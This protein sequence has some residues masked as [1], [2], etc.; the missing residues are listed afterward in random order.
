[1]NARPRRLIRRLSLFLAGGV[2]LC[3]PLPWILNLAP[4]HQSLLARLNG[5]L[6]GQLTVDGLSFSPYTSRLELRGLVLL[7]RTGHP[8]L[9]V[10][11]LELVVSLWSLTRRELNVRLLDLEDPWVRLETGPDGRLTLL[12]V[13][14]PLLVPK[15]DPEIP[16]AK[17]PFR[18]VVD[19]L[20]ITGL[21]LSLS[22]YAGLDTAE[23]A[24][25][26]L[27]ASGAWPDRRA[28]VDLGL[29]GLDLDVDSHPLRLDSLAFAGRYEPD[30]L[31]H[32][33]LAASG[34]G[35]RLVLKGHAAAPW[36]DTRVDVTAGWRIDL[37]H[38]GLQTWL[39]RSGGGVLHGKLASQGSLR[40]PDLQA[41]LVLTG[42]EHAP[43]VLDSL[44]ADLDL[45]GRVLT[46]NERLHLADGGTQDMEARVDAR[47]ALPGGVWDSLR[48]GALAWSVESAWQNLE[49]APWQPASLASGKLHGELAADG[50]GI[51]WPGLTAETRL[52]LRVTELR[53]VGRNE[54]TGGTATLEGRVS[55]VGWRVDDLLVRLPG[56]QV[57]ARGT[58]TH[59]RNDVSLRLDYQVES[60]RLPL[61]APVLD[62]DQGVFSGTLAAVG[63]WRDPRV[64]LAARHGGG[65]LAGVA[66]DSLRLALGL[67]AGTLTLS[68]DTQLTGGGHQ[69]LELLA[70]SRVARTQGLS[71]WGHPEAADWNTTL[72]VDSLA[73]A[74]LFPALADSG[75][76]TGSLQAT[77]HG[78][79]PRRLAADATLRLEGNGL[80]VP[81][82]RDP[83]LLS[84]T[85]HMTA[86]AGVYTLDTLGLGL[87]G[88]ELTGN[89]RVDLIRETLQGLA[90]VDVPDLST[91]PLD[92]GE[93]LAG[94]LSA[95]LAIGGALRAPRAELRLDADDL[96]TPWQDV[97][98]LDLRV[99][100]SGDSTRVDTCS[101]ILGDG[102]GL[103]ASGGLYP[104]E[105]FDVTLSSDPLPLTLFKLVRGSAQVGG[106]VE[107]GLTGGGTRAHPLVDGWLVGRGF[108]FRGTDLPDL[109]LKVTGDGDSLNLIATQFFNLNGSYHPASGAVAARLEIPEQDLDAYLAMAGMGAFSLRT[110]VFLAMDGYAQSLGQLQ[111]RL[112]VPSLALTA[113]DRPIA[114]ARDMAAVWHHGQLD[115]ESIRLETPLDGFLEITGS[116]SPG[117]LALALEADLP[118]EL[119]VPFSPDLGDMTGRL[120][121]NGGL[122]GTLAEPAPMLAA[123]VRGLGMMVPTLE[124]RMHHL[125]ADLRLANGRMTLENLEGSLEGGRF[126]ASGYLTLAGFEPDSINV[127]VRAQSLELELPG[128]ATATTELDLKAFG[129][130]RHS[131]LTGQVQLLEGL[132]YGDINLSPGRLA[133]LVARGREN[134][135]RAEDSGSMPLLRNMELDLA[136]RHRRPFIVENNLLSTSLAP[137]LQLRGRLLEPLPSGRASLGGGTLRFAGRE[138]EI[139]RGIV[140]FV[141]PDVIDPELDIESTVQVTSRD[142]GNSGSWRITL[143]VTGTLA[144]PVLQL[145]SDPREEDE[146]V[147]AILL[148]GHRSSDLGNLS[149]DGE[150]DPQ[151]VLT[152][153][154]IAS[155]GEGL[156]KFSGLDVLAVEM[157]EGNTE[158]DRLKLTVGK[159]LSRRLITYYALEA[160]TGRLLRTATAEYQLLDELSLS[161]FQNSNREVG[162]ELKLKKEFR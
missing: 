60:A 159:S 49:L 43:L 67:D 5:R 90:S 109:D 156:R 114:N 152:K 79:D 143:G 134:Q 2:V 72:T 3:V 136:V 33:D 93:P 16:A 138:F 97:K 74:P 120:Q 137:D 103:Y 22:R 151:Q 14:D 37:D 63:P 8:L 24:N 21:G 51:T 19:N 9:R 122:A 18:I 131:R 75:Q 118:L 88:M 81:G 99:L 142:P 28:T 94:S 64:T 157:G 127:R 27:T 4:V 40:D 46:V 36:P 146:D 148:T 119:A 58:G 128:V 12:A 38:P 130:T 41:Q 107:L 124:Q 70:E 66:I 73:L 20:R 144:A 69:G 155:A 162:G 115:V 54:T 80:Q 95:R 76:V 55:P 25:L 39:G 89:A 96:V 110:R 92:L 111:A 126:Q 105:R 154:L 84:A 11:R 65:V 106:E 132:Y 147:L 48:T 98:S 123:H 85:G 31:H 1:M 87:A 17:D 42:M 57:D 83:G 108:V 121:L 150:L 102:K 129:N 47:A 59:K 86:A 62:K 145:E 113:Y 7:D 15:P 52:A 61:S 100:H 116:G 50:T 91:L 13:F 77:G 56:L 153:L 140:D 117:E 45:A 161:G 6:D 158:A 23:L 104:G 35:I 32:I 78:I 141:N 135:A 139:V 101:V 53:P 133:G 29:Q 44:L 160:G 149:G 34:T 71:G 125:D 68:Q 112:T 10:A 30:S 26:D 82:M